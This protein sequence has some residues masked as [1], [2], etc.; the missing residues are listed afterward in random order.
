M[1]KTGSGAVTSFSDRRPSRIAASSCRIIKRSR[2]GTLRAIIKQVGLTV[3][4]F[5][6]LLG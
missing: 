4:E 3:D 1:S 5:K 6:K 2:R